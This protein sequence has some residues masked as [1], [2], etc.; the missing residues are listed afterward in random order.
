[1]KRNFILLALLFFTN[2][3]IS[4]VR[5]IYIKYAPSSLLDPF[6]PS[7]QFAVE[8]Q[9]SFFRTLHYDL[10]Y[11][12][13]FESL[14]NRGNLKGYR[15]RME[16]RIYPYGMHTEQRNFFHGPNIIA[17]Q[18]IMAKN[19]FVC[20]TPDC[21]SV[22]QAPAVELT[23]SIGPGYGLGWN[24]IFPSGFILEFELVSG[25]VY[26][27]NEDLGLPPLSTQPLST[28]AFFEDQFFDF[29]DTFVPTFHFIFRVGLGVKKK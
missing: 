11:I 19:T 8:Q 22:I 20:V 25:L 7:I 16:Y 4:Q 29:E 13:P 24:K 14:L 3:A 10:G 27:F 6:T 26:F 9:L 1:M 28:P 17:K 15:A 2:I 21:V 5:P 12:F 18:T 23:T